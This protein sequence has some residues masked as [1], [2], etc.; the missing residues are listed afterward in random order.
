M[1]CVCVVTMSC[2][3][4]ITGFI[5]DPSNFFI[6]LLTLTLTSITA[7]SQA[8]AISSRLTVIA[9]A[10]MLVALSFVLFLVRTFTQ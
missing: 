9:I 4:C 7:A 5:V 8:F 6:F 3:F 10:N 1:A 2:I